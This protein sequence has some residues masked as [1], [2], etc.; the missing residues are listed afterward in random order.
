MTIAQVL[1]E[2]RLIR[3]RWSD[4]DE[5]GRELLCLYTALVGTP[6]SRPQECPEALA[7]QWLAHMLPWMDD[8]GSES[9]WRSMVERVARLA[10]R[11]GELTAACEWRV[12]AR[13]V[14]EAMRHTTEQ[15]VLAVCERVARLCERRGAGETVEE[16]EFVS[17]EREAAA[18]AAEREAAAAATRAAA[19]A[20]EREAAAARGAARAAVWAA[21]WEAVWEAVWEATRAAEAAARGATRAAAVVDR[22]T[23]AILDEIEADLAAR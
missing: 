20:A 18:A 19:A 16:E 3:G 7:P 12:R 6:D 13:I 5:Q 9:A 11:F 10:P 15:P 22:L 8:S 4:T 14:R 23:T 21:A 1:A 17:A 2:G